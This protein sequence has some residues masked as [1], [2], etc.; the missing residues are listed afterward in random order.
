MATTTAVSTSLDQALRALQSDYAVLYNKLRVYHWTVRGQ[1]FFM[2]HEMFEKLYKEAADDQDSL[3]ER[4]VALDLEPAT[5]LREELATARLKE[6][7][8]APHA[9]EMVQNLIADLLAVTQLLRELARQAAQVSDTA[10]VNM[11]DGIA[12]RNEKTLWMLRA[13][14]SKTT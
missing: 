5:T 7:P 9:L 4:M 14:L 8:V 10:T 6:D 11:A 13:L 2:L 3:A 1:Q 12:D